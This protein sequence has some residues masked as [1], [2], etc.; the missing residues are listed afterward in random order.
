MSATTITIPDDQTTQA[1]AAEFEDPWAERRIRSAGPTAA[2]LAE[3]RALCREVE[4]RPR[5]APISQKEMGRRLARVIERAVEEDPE[6][7]ERAD[8]QSRELI[9]VMRSGRPDALERLARRYDAI[10]QRRDRKDAA[11]EARLEKA[12]T[13]GAVRPRQQRRRRRSTVRV[14][15]PGGRKKRHRGRRSSEEPP[16]GRPQA[17]HRSGAGGAA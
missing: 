13:P 4:A 15:K 11:R 17:E 3:V 2:E 10:M 6:G 12:V 9:R 8:R 5:R 1:E 7:A 14:S 16:L